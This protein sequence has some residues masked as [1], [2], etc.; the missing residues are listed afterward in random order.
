M[1]SSSVY[2]LFTETVLQHCRG[3]NFDFMT[4]F[5]LIY[6]KEKDEYNVKTIGLGRRYVRFLRKEGQTDEE[7]KQEAIQKFN[8]M[9]QKEQ[10]IEG[11]IITSAYVY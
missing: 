2:L 5:F 7:F 3:C 9:V 8:E 11:E 6:L 10:I 4:R 1:A